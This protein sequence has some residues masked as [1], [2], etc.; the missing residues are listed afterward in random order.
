MLSLLVDRVRETNVGF[1]S[2]IS[3]FGGRSLVVSSIVLVQWQVSLS[4][5][6]LLPCVEGVVSSFYVLECIPFRTTY[7]KGDRN[8]VLWLFSRSLGFYIQ[9]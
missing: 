8:H 3:S 2:A 9:P 5:D 4:T 1:G 7:R 6:L